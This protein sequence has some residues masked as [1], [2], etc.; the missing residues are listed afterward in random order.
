MPIRTQNKPEWQTR[1]VSNMMKGLPTKNTI[2]FKLHPAKPKPCQLHTNS[3][4]FRK[5]LPAQ[6]WDHYMRLPVSKK[7][8]QLILPI[9]DKSV[10]R[11]CNWEFWS[12]D[13]YLVR[14][15][16]WWWCR[17]ICAVLRSPAMSTT[18]AV[19]RGVTKAEWKERF[20]LYAA[21]CHTLCWTRAA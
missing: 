11:L 21:G 14:T 1:E 16:K 18:V 4:L 13:N 12:P 5:P 15:C 2:S 17:T 19:K 3:D 8:A 6:K 10:K 9:T 7:W 20:H